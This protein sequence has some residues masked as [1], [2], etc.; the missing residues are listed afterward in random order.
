MTFN[1]RTPRPNRGY[2]LP[3]FRTSTNRANLP[4]PS[5]IYADSPYHKETISA[6]NLDW[7]KL[8]KWL[9]DRFIST[10]SNI[11]NVLEEHMMQHD[12]HYFRTP[13]KLSQTDKDNI[14]KLRHNYDSDTDPIK[15][16]GPTP[17]PPL[18]D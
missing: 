10:D 15:H 7:F 2:T 13:Q 6:Y 8:K 11:Q 17:D 12:V 3:L 9:V 14:E 16:R 1:M 4:R 18:S 5:T